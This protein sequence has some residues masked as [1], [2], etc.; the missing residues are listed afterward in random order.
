[1]M[2]EANG[3]K[4]EEY[5]NKFEYPNQDLESFFEEHG[6]SKFLTDYVK[7]RVT[8]QDYEIGLA[9]LLARYDASV[10]Q[11]DEKIGNL[12]SELKRQGKWNETA[13]F[14][15]ADHGES[16]TEHGIYFDHH[17]LY[18]Q[19][20][21]IPLIAD[22]PGIESQRRDEFI[23][24]IDLFPTILS[25]FDVQHNKEYDG[26]NLLPLLKEQ[27]TDSRRDGVF[28]EEAYTQRRV[29]I[30]T[31]EWKYITHRSDETLEQKWGSSLECGYCNLLHG[32]PEELY[33]LKSDPEEQQNCI[34][35]HPS[36]ATD[37]RSQIEQFEESVTY[38]DIG[39]DRAKPEFEDEDEVMQRL[40][41]LG[42][43]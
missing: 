29:A 11:V 22:I 38:P 37:L 1:M 16:L 35:E 19:T 41:D 12:V 3:K 6:N 7:D 31:E 17:G 30:R 15:M 4:I 26:K 18:D 33:H 21:H 39:A 36:V 9:R 23:Q 25:L 28:I 40:E 2:Y 34:D 27:N 24:P 13:L 5:L 42:Y 14:V 32:E 43:Q 20:T 10:T 8:E